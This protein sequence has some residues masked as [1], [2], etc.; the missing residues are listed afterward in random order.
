M[1]REKGAG[2]VGCGSCGSELDLVAQPDG[3]VAVSAC[4]SCY[5]T[6]QKAAMAPLSFGPVRAQ[7]VLGTEA[8]DE[9]GNA[10]D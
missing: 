5:P 6:T 2:R 3:S 8:N 9:Q 4:G 7:R 1:E 10:D